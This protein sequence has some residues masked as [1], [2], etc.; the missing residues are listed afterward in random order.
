M[1]VLLHRKKMNNPIINFDDFHK[2]L[3]RRIFLKTE[4]MNTLVLCVQNK[5]RK[6]AF[7]G[8][9][10]YLLVNLEMLYALM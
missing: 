10:A 2:E 8:I 9:Y 1:N 7:R 5:S 3:L 4:Y 6:A